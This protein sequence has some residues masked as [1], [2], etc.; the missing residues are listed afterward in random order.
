M[1][2]QEELKTG[3]FKATTEVSYLWKIFKNY[4]VVKDIYLARKTLKC[5]RKFGFVRFR[6]D[7]GYPQ[8]EK[9]LNNIW[10]G[11]FKLRVYR[12]YSRSGYENIIPKQRKEGFKVDRRRSY[13]EVVSGNK[14][15]VNL[16]REEDSSDG[17][18][19]ILGN[20]SP[21]K[22]L[23]PY[24]KL[25]T[26][27]EIKNTDHLESI[28]ML[29]REK[30]IG[31]DEVKLLGGRQILLKFSDEERLSGVVENKNHGIHFWVKDL[32]RWSV[33]FRNSQRL[34]WLKISGMPLHSW[35]EEVFSEIASKWGTVQN[36]GFFCDPRIKLIRRTL[37]VTL[38]YLVTLDV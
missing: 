17:I 1:D 28:R 29:S 13:A 23:E 5:G 12:A 33:G 4:G 31:I 26:V 2:T 21:V 15:D 34:V 32:S 11:L 25:C 27:G 22:K 16:K 10:I 14:E 35:C 7:E 9:R 19:E 8:L 18:Q 38:K 36:V 20:W 30:L 6:K 3:G 24:L 37:S